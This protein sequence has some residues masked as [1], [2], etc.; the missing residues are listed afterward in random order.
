MI[1][2]GEG[3]EGTI[4]LVRNQKTSKLFAMKTML[5]TEDRMKKFVTNDHI[6]RLMKIIEAC[7]NIIEIIETFYDENYIQLIC[8]WAEQGSL[9]E[10][11]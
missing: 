9:H 3:S 6:T 5:R 2:L 10:R 4:T 11:I 7:P 1:Y 8:E